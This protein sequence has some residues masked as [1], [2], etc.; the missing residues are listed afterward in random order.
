MLKQ[1]AEQIKNNLSNEGVT[2]KSFTL[3]SEGDYAFDDADWNY[4]DI[5]HLKHV[6][7]LVESHPTF[8]SDNQVNHII[9]QKIPPF[10]KVFEIV[11]EKK[12]NT[13]SN[14]A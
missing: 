12:S 8:A 7:N 11:S 2:F 9:F 6:H 5:P 1:S 4:K 14:W 10:F 3:T 13:V